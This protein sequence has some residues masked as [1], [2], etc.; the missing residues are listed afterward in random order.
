MRDCSITLSLFSERPRARHFQK[1]WFSCHQPEK[2]TD[3]IQPEWACWQSGFWQW[4]F[5]TTA[6]SGSFVN[7]RPL[8]P[9]NSLQ[10]KPVDH[11][12]V[13]GWLK[14]H[15]P[16]NSPSS[17]LL[18][19]LLLCGILI[20]LACLPILSSSSLYSLFL[21]MSFPICVLFWVACPPLLSNVTLLFSLKF[22]LPWPKSLGHTA[23]QGWAI[24]PETSP[25]E[26]L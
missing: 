1:C 17:T 21:A 19:T 5:D 22:P 13:S 14:Q 26:C 10:M 11:L 18:L 4:G 20:Y 9:A 8:C 15:F 6:S 24:I 2:A 7:L 12:T 3:P 25:N 16:V 23:V